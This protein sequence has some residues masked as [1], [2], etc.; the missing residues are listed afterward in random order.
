[1]IQRVGVFLFFEVLAAI[2]GVVVLR[3]MVP[4]RD[5]FPAGG[6]VFSFG[7]LMDSM[8][9]LAALFAVAGVAFLV[10]ATPERE[11]VRRVR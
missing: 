3:V 6:G 2:T 11:R 5:S 8:S 10:F 7:V 9:L 1:V 4:I